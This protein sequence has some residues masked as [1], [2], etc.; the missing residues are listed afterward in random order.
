[1]LRRVPERVF[2]S[3]PCDPDLAALVHLAAKAGV[4]FET[5]AGGISPYRAVTVIRKVS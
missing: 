2:V 5:R 4:P 1:M 3:D